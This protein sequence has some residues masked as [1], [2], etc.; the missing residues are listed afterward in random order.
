MSD[1]HEAISDKTS[2]QP[3]TVHGHVSKTVLGV[4]SFACG[5]FVVG[6]IFAAP[7]PAAVASCGISVMG[8]GVGFFML[9]R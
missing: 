1:N 2:G 8:L 9:R 6:S 7:W 4:A 5:T 3:D